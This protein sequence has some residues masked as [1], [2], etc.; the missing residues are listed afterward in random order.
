MLLKKA[1]ALLLSL[2][3]VSVLIGCSSGEQA[4][5]KASDSEVKQMT[6]LRTIFDG[7]KGD[8]SQLTPAQKQK[9]LDYAKGNQAQADGVWDHMKNPRGKSAEGSRPFSVG[10]GGKIMPKGG[11]PGSDR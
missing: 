1:G 11:T 3:F 7:V 5:E 8:Y 10:P 6:E 9:F 4:V 2:V